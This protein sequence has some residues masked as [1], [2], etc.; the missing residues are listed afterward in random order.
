MILLSDFLF[1]I[2]VNCVDYKEVINS[3]LFL[4]KYYFFLY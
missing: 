2:G 3:V 4:N 1:V